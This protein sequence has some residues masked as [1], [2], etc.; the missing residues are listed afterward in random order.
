MSQNKKNIYKF[1]RHVRYFH[2]V[3]HFTKLKS[4]NLRYIQNAF[5]DGEKKNYDKNTLFLQTI[6]FNLKEHKYIKQQK[7]NF[8]KIIL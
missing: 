6:I 7:N 2:N 5:M 1:F 4:E 8:N 3:A